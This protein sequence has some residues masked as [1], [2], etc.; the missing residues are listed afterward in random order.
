[1]ENS[2]ELETLSSWS[3]KK[4]VSQENIYE[5][6]G[7]IKSFKTIKLSFDPD[8]LKP[9][10]K[11]D[12]PEHPIEIKKIEM[13]FQSIITPFDFALLQMQY[14]RPWHFITY[15]IKRNLI[16]AISTLIVMMVLF[17]FGWI[18]LNSTPPLDAFVLFYVF[19]AAFG[20]SSLATVYDFQYQY[21]IK[22][23]QYLMLR[24][25]D[26]SWLVATNWLFCYI[27][28]LIHHWL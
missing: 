4:N 26:F 5:N 8:D 3:I 13:E 21:L 28:I 17:G 12:D 20:A 9:I 27:F 16:S 23:R 18:T 22:F 1:M 10:G 24:L 11:G 7:L 25:I 19:L 14:K 6:D 2:K 15:V